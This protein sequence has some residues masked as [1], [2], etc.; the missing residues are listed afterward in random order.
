[1]KIINE[2]IIGELKYLVVEFDCKEFA[3]VRGAGVISQGAVR[4]YFEGKRPDLKV[5][6]CGGLKLDSQRDIVTMRF[7][8]KQKP[9]IPGGS[10]TLLEDFDR[11]EK[12]ADGEAVPVSADC[13]NYNYCC[14]NFHLMCLINI[15]SMTFTGI[16]TSVTIGF[17][18]NFI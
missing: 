3:D 18:A 5:K 2:E 8:V 1:M 10:K 4:R 16:A 7:G 12:A 6:K 13:K 9:S 15:A 14:E 11:I 17:L